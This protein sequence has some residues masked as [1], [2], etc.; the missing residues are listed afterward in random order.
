MSPH[1]TSKGAGIFSS[2][3]GEVIEEAAYWHNSAGAYWLW[4]IADSPL[5][6][7]MLLDERDEFAI[8]AWRR[9][10]VPQFGW[11]QGR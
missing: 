9:D 2:G 5:D 6:A 1:W 8:E 3:R 4:L 11:P 7:P 10:I